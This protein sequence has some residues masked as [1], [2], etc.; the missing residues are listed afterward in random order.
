MI[1]CFKFLVA[2]VAIKSR[3]AF[4]FSAYYYGQFYYLQDKLANAAPPLTWLTCDEWPY[5]NKAR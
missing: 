1:V 2:K 3:L 4:V 5:T